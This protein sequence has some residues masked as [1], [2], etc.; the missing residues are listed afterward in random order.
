LKALL[1]LAG[2]VPGTVAVEEGQTLLE[3]ALAAGI[4]LRR[5][6][7]NGSCRACLARLSQGQ[8]IY[9]VAW[10]GLL[11]EERAEGFVLPCVAT[12][13]SAELVLVNWQ[14]H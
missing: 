4:P 13:A 3:A 7:R 10:P 2:S 6:C 8:V 12:A 5:S 1:H 9:R 11:A 14:A